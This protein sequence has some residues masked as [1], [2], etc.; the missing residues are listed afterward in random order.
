MRSETL[1]VEEFIVGYLAEVEDHLSVSRASLVA[2]DASLQRHEAN[3]KAVR[4][5]FRS[6]HTI[7]GLSAMVGAEPI[8][9]ISHEL[10]TLLRTAD[11]SA[12][13]LPTRAVD[14]IVQGLRAIEER[15]GCLSR[16][17]PLAPAPRELIEALASLE[18]DAQLPLDRGAL[19]LDPELLAK[20]SAAE[21]T[22]LLDGIARGRR[23]LRVDFV[24]TRER[25]ARG[26]NITA[27]RTQ[28]EA[29]G[30]LV[31]VIPRSLLPTEVGGGSIAFVLLLLTD[32]ADAAITAIT[33]AAPQPLHSERAA[34]IASVDEV[35]LTAIEQG[36][37]QRNVIR[38]EVTRLDEALEVLSTLMVTRARLLRAVANVAQGQGALRDLNPI[39]AE[40]G[41]QLRDLRAAIMS[42]RMVP[43]IEMLERTP[44]LVRGLSRS[45]RKQVALHIDAGHSELD[46]SVADRLSPAIVHLLRNAVDH[47]IELPDQRVALG[48]PAEGRIEVSCMATSS[49]HLRL[50]ISDDGCG[51]DAQKVARR[52]G[53]PLPAD[54]AEL[55][56]LITRPGLSTLD[57]PTHTS[58]R[59]LG[60]DIVK[61]IV[62]DE[63]GGQLQ[64]QTTPGQG[65][66][67]ILVV[68]LT[69]T[70]LDAFSF[71]SAERI[72]VV[73]VSAVEDL[74][75][76]EAERI[77]PAPHPGAREGQ[78][79]LLKHRGNTLPL[80]TLSEVLG[81]EA[82]TGLRPK[83]IIVR[84]HDQFF[85]FEVDKMI[86]QQEV[87]VRP[88]RDALVNVRG[89]SGSTDLGDGQPTLVLDLLALVDRQVREV[90]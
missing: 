70:I 58:G 83:A 90:A 36:Q 33:D 3:P 21:Q 81:Y 40:N 48:K 29:L 62:V 79:R 73:P 24:P 75:E 82:R 61:R 12:G 22:Q 60:M 54:D 44:L 77:S 28:L 71:V 27:V 89:I 52:A 23:A 50:V 8:V 84:K 47:A 41:R 35:E 10:E 17:E 57:T 13:Q 72:F 7:K 5:L 49:S 16:H 43:V 6:L 20:V 80:Y 85:A 4:E 46:K 67:F 88:L 63:L 31:K 69:V 87:V 86:S 78:V 37:Q 30:E 34:P 56:A 38:V 68:P 11:R 76:L 74:V 65:T 26:L 45:S 66:R 19:S 64:L 53:K 1:D 9:D 25:A 59:G 39:L 14:Q 51:I 15:I 2:L 42:A 55:L 18:V 32:A